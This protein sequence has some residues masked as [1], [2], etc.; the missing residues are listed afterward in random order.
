MTRERCGR[1]IHLLYLLNTDDPLLGVQI[2]NVQWLPLYYCFDF[3]VP[4][5]GY[6]LT[7]DNGAD[8]FFRPKQ[9]NGLA[10][11]SYPDENFK[12]AFPRA[13][14][15]LF[16]LPYDPSDPSD[17]RS[18]AGIFGLERLSPSDLEDVLDR[19]AQEIYRSGRQLMPGESI[20]DYLTEPFW[21]GK[22]NNT[23]PNPAC[24]KTALDVF[25]LIPSE[26]VPDVQVFGR[27]GD[28]VRLIFELC[29][30]CHAINVS[31]ECT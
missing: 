22:P 6:R 15:E 8:V 4:Q 23:C 19:E 27:D 9:S 25:A 20:R 2:P 11:E 13:D 5:L 18:L 31:N 14:I 24:G 28:F 29:R 16:E 1:T 17:A 7:S 30:E 12:L 21:Q 26:P 3:G 10:V